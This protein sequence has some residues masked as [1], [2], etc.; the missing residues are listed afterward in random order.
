MIVTSRAQRRQLDRDNAKLPTALQ[1]VPRSE[2]P[3]ASLRDENRL[4]VWRSRHFLVQEFKAPAPAQVRLSINR[5][6]IVGD[7]WTAGI[8]WEELQRL[9]NEVG[10]SH[11][12]AV[13]VFPPTVDVVN[14]ANMRHLWVLAEPLAFAWRRR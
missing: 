13:E 14:V 6:S 4:R 9:K 10:Y 5:T 2:W 12:D 3:E 8:E 11:L 1:E 7:R